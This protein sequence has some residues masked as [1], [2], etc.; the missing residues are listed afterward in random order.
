MNYRGKSNFVYYHE[1]T[2]GTP[3]IFVESFSDFAKKLGATIDELDEKPINTSNNFCRQIGFKNSPLRFI[4]FEDS[5]LRTLFGGRNKAVIDSTLAL[6]VGNRKYPQNE[7]QALEHALKLSIK[8][9]RR[10]AYTLLSRLYA[11]NYNVETDL[12]FDNS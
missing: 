8:E 9:G 6:Y 5:M 12:R 1:F 3:I 4:V 10:G 11:H 7:K 2:R